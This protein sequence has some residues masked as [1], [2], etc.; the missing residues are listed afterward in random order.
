MGWSFGSCYCPSPA[1]GSG[2]LT[3]GLEPRPCSAARLSRGNKQCQSPKVL[4]NNK[5]KCTD[6][7]ERVLAGGR[8]AGERLTLCEEQCITGAVLL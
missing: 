1:P 7:P 3:A 5:L 2:V 8:S 6:C 4:E